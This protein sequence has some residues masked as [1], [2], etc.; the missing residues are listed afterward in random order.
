MAVG[1]EF[2]AR[3]VCRQIDVFFPDDF[4][5]EGTIANNIANALR[6]TEQCIGSIIAW[7]NKGFD[8]L[9]SGQYAIFLYFLSN[10][11]WKNSG[12]NDAAT[13]LFLLNKAL[14]GIDLFYEIE[15]P[16]Y[17]AIA[18]TSGMVFSKGAY[19]EYCA[20]HQGCTVGRTG[21]GHP[22]LER[23]VIMF[24]G[25]MIA[26]KCLVREN[27]VIA[28]GTILINTDTPGNCYVFP[29]RGS[30]PVFKK[31]DRYYADEYFV[32]SDSIL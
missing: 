22:T 12:N 13:R 19:G 18:H 1:I 16:R 21:E 27:T 11:I 20:F 4:S 25:S 17:F 28:A 2:L 24:P 8:Y 7:R 23:G 15:M 32:R 31:L 6:A 5:I 29:G 10:S 30:R 9:V 14:N 26:G 3:Y